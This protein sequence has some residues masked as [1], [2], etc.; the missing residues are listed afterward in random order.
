MKLL[1]ITESI[2]FPPR[3]G[4]E[5]PTARIFEQFMQRHEVDL[6]VL[7]QDDADYKARLKYLP[8]GIHKTFFIPYTKLNP[9]KRAINELFFIKPAYFFR[10]FDPLRIEKILADKH[11]DFAWVNPPGNLDLIRLCQKNGI[12]LCDHSILGMNDLKTTLYSDEINELKGGNFKWSYLLHWLRSFFI[13]Q[14]E[15]QY[16]TEFDLVHVQ[17]LK[18]KM[19]TVNLLGDMAFA[20]RVIDSPNGVKSFL[21]DCTYQG[22]DQNAILFMTHLDGE[23]KYESKWFITRV[24]PT[25]KTETK[26]D[27]WL[28][29]TPPKTPIPYIDSDPRIKVKG[30][31]PDLVETFNQI[32]LA[33]VPIFHGTGLINRIQD[34]FAAGV[35]CVAS[36]LSASTFPEAEHEEHLLVAETAQ[37]FAAEIIRLYRNRSLRVELS[38]NGRAFAK[39]Q[40]TWQET[41]ARLEGQMNKIIQAESKVEI[42]KK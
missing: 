38:I 8:E 11:Y 20:S 18:E 32:R 34:A 27:L 42:L 23:R 16:L 17:T 13:A 26:A 10:V 15:K 40:P 1:L 36:K 7:G 39:E 22:I 12:S 14:H 2:P 5:L 3:N 4:R 28:V 31:V 25:I 6:L 37:E 30:Y 41:A 29:G 9:L 33:V 21:Y 24:W 19:K 35:P